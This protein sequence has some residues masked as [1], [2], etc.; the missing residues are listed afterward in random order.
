MS[1]DSSFSRTTT[2]RQSDLC[3]PSHRE[4][5]SR[6]PPVVIGGRTGAIRLNRVSDS[7]NPP[8]HERSGRGDKP[9]SVAGWELAA[10]PRCPWRSVRE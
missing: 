1:R 3:S 5:Y 6:E 9:D 2:W 8:K 4:F 7:V 10:S